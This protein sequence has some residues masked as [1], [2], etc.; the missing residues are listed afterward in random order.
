MNELLAVW[1]E[2]MEAV[3]AE[4]ELSIMRQEAMIE[5]ELKVKLAKEKYLIA[6]K[7]NLADELA[8]G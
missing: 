4:V 6:L 5:A 1:K 3:I 8:K 2:Q 7:K